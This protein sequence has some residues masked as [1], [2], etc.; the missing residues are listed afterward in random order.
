MQSARPGSGMSCENFMT[1]S[2]VN[3]FIFYLL[4]GRDSVRQRVPSGLSAGPAQISRNLQVSHYT[5]HLV[6]VYTF[7]I[8]GR[9]E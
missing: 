2:C 3:T 4:V 5:N 7:F 8:K 9:P 6:A 1:M